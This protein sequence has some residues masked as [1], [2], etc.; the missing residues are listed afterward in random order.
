MALK[1]KVLNFYRISITFST[2]MAA[3]KEY[4]FTQRRKEAKS[5]QRFLDNL[6]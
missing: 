1:R 6:E 5:A 2:E 4:R 3:E